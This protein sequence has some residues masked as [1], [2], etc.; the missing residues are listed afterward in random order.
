MKK[1]LAILL[2][3]TLLLSLSAVAFAED[4]LIAPKP[5]EYNSMSG[6]I[7]SYEDGQLEV[8]DAASKETMIFYISEQTYLVDAETGL[9]ADLQNRKTDS[10]VAYYGPAVTMS[11][12]AKAPAIAVVL[13]MPENGLGGA[14]YTKVDQVSQNDEGVTE[15]LCSN[16]S[17]ILRPNDETTYAAFKTKNIVTLADIKEGS[18]LLAWCDVIALSY[19][20]QGTPTKFVVLSTP[21]ENL[22]TPT[23][24]E[25]NDDTKI[26][27]SGTTVK[28][29]GK[30][31]SSPA[32]EKGDTI[33]LPLRAIAEALGFEVIWNGDNSVQVVQGAQVGTLTIGDI[34]YGFAKMIVKLDVAPELTDDL[35]YVPAEFFEEVLHISIAK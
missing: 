20:G 4:L 32:Y 6:E 22:P 8:K 33:M 29:D 35:T 11:L 26:S 2:A 23:S 34:N 25:A 19:P 3:V 7:V 31:I 13:N 21:E 14:F 18:E 10:V 5:A 16:G 12:P 15:L 24:G 17:L 28:V 9:P 27:V 30:E 1:I